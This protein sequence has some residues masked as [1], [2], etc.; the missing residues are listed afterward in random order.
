MLWLYYNWFRSFDLIRT[1]FL[2]MIRVFISGRIDLKGF[3]IIW[4]S[5]YLFICTHSFSYSLHWWTQLLSVSVFR[6]L[7]IF[8]IN[9]IGPLFF[10]LLT[11]T[12]WL[13]FHLGRSAFTQYYLKLFKFI[14]FSSRSF[15]SGTWFMSNGLGL[16]AWY[17]LVGWLLFIFLPFSDI[18][19]LKKLFIWIPLIF[20]IINFSIYFYINNI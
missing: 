9:F 13:Y 18:L 14:L 16:V 15:F 7:F 10:L 2:H 11:V 20:Q 5:G 1:R 6:K 8:Q 3:L 4:L 17:I 19:L 12:L